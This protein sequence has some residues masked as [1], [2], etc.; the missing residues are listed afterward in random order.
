MIIEKARVISN[1]EIKLGYYFLRLF[2]P[3]MAEVAEPGQFA[4]LR[5]SYNN[6]SDP[7]L[8]RPLSFHDASWKKGE[9]SFLY[10][11]KG[12]G[13][14]ELSRLVANGSADVMGPL[15]TGF[16]LPKVSPGKRQPIAIIGCGVGVAPLVFLAS[17]AHNRGYEV[18]TFIG[19]RSE[20]S[21]LVDPILVAK[22]SVLSTATEDG[23]A[24]YH[25]NIVSLLRNKESLVA[26]CGPAYVCGPE[27]A[28]AAVVSLCTELGIPCQVSLESIM[29]CGVGACLG[30]TCNTTRSPNYTRV[31]TEGPV[32]DGEEVVFC[33]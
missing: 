22:S 1:S 8:R 30:C 9:I 26:E 25:G 6:T 31:C 14:K 20:S 21:L 3:K 12:K 24:G 5:C 19:A 33:D 18:R 7:L 13:T 27:A 10:Q 4:M 15:G 23:S 17:T 2:S 29:A 32:F 28:M 11:V 16:R